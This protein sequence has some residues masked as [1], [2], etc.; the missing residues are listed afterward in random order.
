MLAALEVSISP[1][2]YLQYLE[3]SAS[4]E[5]KPKPVTPVTDPVVELAQMLLAKDEK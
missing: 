4:L 5:L 1:K 2:A 3:V